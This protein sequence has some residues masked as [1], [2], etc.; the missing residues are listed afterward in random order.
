MPHKVGI[1]AIKGITSE[2]GVALSKRVTLLDRSNMTVVARTSSDSEGGYVFNGLNAETDDYIVMAV[3]DTADGSGNF[4]QAIVYDK[5]K[6]FPAYMG[7][8]FFGNWAVLAMGKDPI[9]GWLGEVSTNK[10]KLLTHGNSVYYSTASLSNISISNNSISAGAPQIPTISLANSNILI[11]SLYDGG[12]SGLVNSPNE[13]TL[14]F[15]LSQSACKSDIG[16]GGYISA[17]D[18]PSMNGAY[19]D[20]YNTKMPAP[21]VDYNYTQKT[22]SVYYFSS[23]AKADYSQSA[24]NATA[25]VLNLSVA[26]YGDIL[27][28]VVSM[29]LQD[30][31]E[32]Y[33]NGNLAQSV[34]LASSAMHIDS[35]IGSPMGVIIC[36]K[37]TAILPHDTT[38]TITNGLGVFAWYD[39][40]FT[41]NDV[42]AHYN[43]LI[44][45]SLPNITGYAKEVVLDTPSAYFRL[46]EPNNIDYTCFSNYL[47]KSGYNKRRD[48]KFFN[49]ANIGFGQPSIIL[50]GAL[51]KFNGN[52]GAR[53]EGVKALGNTLEYS[54]EFVAKFE[55]EKPTENELIF[56]ATNTDEDIFRGVYRSSDNKFYV[57][58]TSYRTFTTVID[59]ANLHHYAVVVD[60]FNAVAKLYIDGLLVETLNTDKT[61]LPT[62]SES[63]HSWAIA[64]E[65]MIGGIVNDSL[66]SINSAMNGTLGEVAIYDHALTAPRILAHYNAKDTL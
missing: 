47:F 18:Y 40:Q 10:N 37:S 4:K 54:I 21:S 33:V 42:L 29:K 16:I 13:M 44:V 20:R 1:G 14:E 38:A 35:T 11:Y 9:C 28:V 61:V 12:K 25:A 51:A 31:L 8:T 64:G 53:A 23:S 34:S 7:A 17:G 60:K 19:N 5:V 22:L 27:H 39:K 15:L 3:D 58:D 56:A 59:Y 66:N 6:P 52:S 48:A 63:S 26:E 43:A 36:G 55:Q 62:L 24:A 41:S 49:V 2:D 30:K 57:Y 65:Y 45:G 46:S 32:L 50:G